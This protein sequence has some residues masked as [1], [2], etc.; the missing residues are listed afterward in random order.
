MVNRILK[1]GIAVLVLQLLVA[2]SETSVMDTFN[3]GKTSPGDT[4]V[5]TNAPLSLPPDMALRQPG[6]A[7]APAQSGNGLDVQQGQRATPT[8][9]AP[10]PPQPANQQP[11]WQ[12]STA[13]VPSAPAAPATPAQPAN[14]NPADKVYYDHGINPYTSTGARKS[15]SVLNQELRNKSLEKKRAEN[16]NHGTIFNIGELWSDN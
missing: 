1:A 9:Q 2:C 13:T 6:A 8:Y 11:A 16:P 12:N 10:P 4:T 14:I 15:Q 5:S 7:S 3:A